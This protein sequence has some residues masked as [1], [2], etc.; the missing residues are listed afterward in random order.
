VPTVRGMTTPG[1]TVAPTTTITITRAVPA[2]LGDELGIAVADRDVGDVLKLEH[3]VALR[4]VQQDYARFGSPAQDAAA[5]SLG[6]PALRRATATLDFGA[7]AAGAAATMPVAVPKAKVGELVAVAGP[8]GLDPGLVVGASVTA[9]NT[10]T[11][12]VANT[13]A[14][15]IDPAAGEFTVAVVNGS[16][17]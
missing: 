16:R 2:A 17:R 13:T 7:I 4:L 6:Q 14:A 1:A 9:A 10:V 3:D 11:V 12:R 8:A 5:S 15:A